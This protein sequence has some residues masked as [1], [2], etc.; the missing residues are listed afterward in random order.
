[1]D[2]FS[3]ETHLIIELLLSLALIAM[4]AVNIRM[5]EQFRQYKLTHTFHSLLFTVSRGLFSG[6]QTSSKGEEDPEHTFS[7]NESNSEEEE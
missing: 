7:T 5:R 3:I 6:L 4:I 2:F 1:M